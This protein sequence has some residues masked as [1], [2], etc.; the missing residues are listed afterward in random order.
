MASTIIIL[1]PQEKGHTVLL[2]L[3]FF[4]GQLS[5]RAWTWKSFSQ[6][7]QSPLRPVMGSK[8]EKISAQAKL[9]QAKQCSDTRGCF[10][11][12]PKWEHTKSKEILAIPPYMEL[13]AAEVSATVPVSKYVL[14]TVRIKN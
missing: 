10:S 9:G 4:R 5:C 3:G 14:E 1:P 11:L 12:F 2:N 13:V 8:M 7:L 6:R